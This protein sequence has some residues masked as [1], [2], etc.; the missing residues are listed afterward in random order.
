M[1]SIRSVFI[2]CIQIWHGIWQFHLKTMALFPHIW[3]SQNFDLHTIA[4]HSQSLSQ[5]RI[6][7]VYKQISETMQLVNLYLLDRFKLDKSDT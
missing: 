5:V 2:S 7:D 1:Q 6:Y 4:Q 3:F